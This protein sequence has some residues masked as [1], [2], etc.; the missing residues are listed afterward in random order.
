MKVLVTGGRG[1]LATT[2]VPTLVGAGHEV[3][4]PGREE[5]DVTDAVAVERALLDRRPDAVVQ[6]AAYTAVDR[7]EAEEAEAH[8]LNAE[9]AGIVARSCQSVGSVFVYPSTDYVFPGEGERPFRP[10]DPTGPVNA[11]GRSKLAGEEAAR[12]AGRALVV[13]TSW[14]YGRGGPNFVETIARLASERPTLEVVDDQIGRPTWTGTLAEV[15]LGLLERAAIGTFHASDG[16]DPV[17]WFDFAREIVK[18]LS[19]ETCIL[20]VPTGAVPRPARRP[21]YSVLDLAE[22]A[23]LLGRPLPDWRT[24]LDR[25]LRSRGS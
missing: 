2:L 18:R 17:S 9:A 6:C 12:G 19:L 7:A 13:R 20:P 15:L 1:M 4:A 22:T 8:R 11:Y 24:A 5:L 23:A 3:W 16:G 25:Y 21:R 14:L 10:T